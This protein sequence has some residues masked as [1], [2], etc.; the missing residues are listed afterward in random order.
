ME[1]TTPVSQVHSGHLV[2]PRT[3][4]TQSP[5]EGKWYLPVQC[6][7]CENPPCVKVCPVGATFKGD[8]GL[9]AMDYDK[10]ICCRNCMAACPYN[11]RRFN[12]AAPQIP[13]E[14]VNPTVIVRQK[15]VV[16]KCTFCSRR[17]R[18]GRPPRLRGGL[19]GG[20][21]TLRRSQGP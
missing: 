15:G 16:E 5:Q 19:P 21:E 2:E 12:L 8:D 6:F 4:Y 3:A 11:A 17:V 10:C 18:E 13:P 7:H 1:M 9:V 20:G 14:K